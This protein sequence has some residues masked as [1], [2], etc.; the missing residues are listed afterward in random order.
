[1]DLKLSLAISAGKILAFVIKLFGGGGTAA[2]GL[3]AL[4]IDP[5][6]A[7]WEVDEATLPESIKNVYPKT[8]V[9]LNL[10]RDQLD[11]Y[12]EVDSTRT[13]WQKALR[14]LPKNTSLILNCDDPG[15]SILG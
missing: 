15:I 1:M 11:R 7:I 10:F 3:V 13:K 5:N 6:L 4:K 12:G 14:T 9:L 2:P 8:I